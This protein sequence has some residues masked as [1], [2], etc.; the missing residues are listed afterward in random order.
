MVGSDEHI[1]SGRRRHIVSESCSKVHKHIS[2]PLHPTAYLVT[3]TNI[4]LEAT[5]S[6]LKCRCSIIH[7]LQHI[8]T[9]QASFTSRYKVVQ[10]EVR[11][12]C[13]ADEICM[14]SR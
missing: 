2:T 13:R 6:R 9:L 12:I 11:A 14:R 4:L 3:C 10:Q 5:I 1:S 8:T 7:F